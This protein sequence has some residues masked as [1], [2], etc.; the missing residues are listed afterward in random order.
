M[1]LWNIS[2]FNSLELSIPHVVDSYDEEVIQAEDNFGREEE[3]VYI[4]TLS[5][6]KKLL[7]VWMYAGVV[8]LLDKAH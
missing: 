2:F 6:N 3:C 1:K 7:R 4:D 8:S 5:Y